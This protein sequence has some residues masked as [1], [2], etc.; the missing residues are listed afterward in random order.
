LYDTL[1][2]VLEYQLD[3]GLSQY[4]MINHF[5]MQMGFKKYHFVNM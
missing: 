5:N 2:T 3:G 4:V 1:F